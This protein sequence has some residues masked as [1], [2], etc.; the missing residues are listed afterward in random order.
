METQ[1]LQIILNAAS[2]P[3]GFSGHCHCDGTPMTNLEYAKYINN[4]ANDSWH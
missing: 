1:L 4:P 2:D 3:N